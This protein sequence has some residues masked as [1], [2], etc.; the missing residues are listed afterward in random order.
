MTQTADKRPIM[1]MRHVSKRFDA[2]QALEDVSLTLYP[3]E[4]HALIGENGAG[5]STLIKIMTGV[6]RPDVG[7]ILLDG[8][9]V[10]IRNSQEA[11]AHGIAAIYQEPMVFPDLNVAENIF[12]SHQ[13]RGPI[14]QWGKAYRDAEAILAQLGVKLDVRE[15][16][17]GLTLAAQQAVEIARAISLKVRVLIM[18]EPTASLSAHEVTQLFKLV[19]SLRSQGVAILFIGHRMEEVFRIGD[20]IT[21]LRDGKWISSTPRAEV[22]TEQIIRDM[23]GRKIEDFF[24]KSATQRG[25]LLMSVRNLGKESIFRDVNF[26][27]YAGEVLG[28]AG[29]IGARRTDVGL[30]LFGV[31]PADTGEITFEGQPQKIVSPEQALQAGI[32]YVT[33]DRRNLGLTMTMPMVSNITLPTL[34]KY[35][36]RLGL[37]KR[38]A[39]TATAEAYRQKLDIRSPSVDV[40]VG[41]LS[42]GNQ[43]KVVLSKWLN[44]QPKLLILDEP[45]RGI[46]VR[47]KAEVHHMVSD[48]AAQGLGII[49]ISSDLPEVLAMSDRILVMREGRQM[50][51]F[52]RKEATQEVVMTAA[53]GQHR[54]D[55][56]SRTPERPQ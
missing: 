56:S 8:K 25:P 16:A 53:M 40:Q 29:L 1:E 48:L 23:V 46:D 19:A 4:V 18:D 12:I 24:A 39:E 22:K 17:R 45:T 49:L 9:P 42:G 10:Q 34:S 37:V 27:V 5:K 3:G 21:V 15:A 51:I 14:V 11:Q 41:K 38:A 30:A 36:T 54:E 20:R 32:A 28:F 35:L 13:D 44:A 50:G 47:T 52:D 6:H 55:D 7:E 2:T 26:D 31:E 43:Q 33:E